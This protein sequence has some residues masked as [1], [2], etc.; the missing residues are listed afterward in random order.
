[1]FSD[2][3]AFRIAVEGKK[4]TKDHELKL[5][6]RGAQTSCLHRGSRT[7]SPQAGKMPAIPYAGWKPALPLKSLCL[8]FAF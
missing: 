1:L 6:Q 8:E 3:D 5:T 2:S 4:I 7:S